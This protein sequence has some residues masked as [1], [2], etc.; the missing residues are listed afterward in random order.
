MKNKGICLFR[1]P[2]ITR[3]WLHSRCQAKNWA[4]LCSL[5]EAE[6]IMEIKNIA[7][8]TKVKMYETLVIPVFMYGSECWTLRKEDE[9]RIEAAEMN[10]LRK[11]LRI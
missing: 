1:R 7:M 8:S 10:W 3:W 5:R 11:I 6:Q 2:D 9:H 4:S